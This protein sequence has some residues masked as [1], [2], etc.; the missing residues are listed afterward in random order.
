MADPVRDVFQRPRAVPLAFPDP[1]A[2]AGAR[3]PYPTDPAPT[4]A[5]TASAAA[6]DCQW[7]TEHIDVGG[8]KPTSRTIP[9]GVRVSRRQSPARFG[10]S[11]GYGVFF[12]SIYSTFRSRCN[13]P[14][15]IKPWNDDVG[16]ILRFVPRGSSF[17]VEWKPYGCPGT[18]FAAF[19]ATYPS[20]YFGRS[21]FTIRFS[22]RNV[23]IRY[24]RLSYESYGGLATYKLVIAFTSRRPPGSGGSGV[25]YNPRR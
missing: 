18:G 23:P 1:G 9:A 11:R 4:D 5:L 7:T 17:V 16:P 19:K 22:G 6:S 8:W 2:G 21:E 25:I 24:Q 13:L 20:A 15:E 3:E 14:D 10:L 12:S